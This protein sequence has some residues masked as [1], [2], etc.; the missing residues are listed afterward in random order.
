MSGTSDPRP[1]DLPFLIAD[2]PR[3]P[4]PLRA[5]LIA[6][7]LR[8]EQWDLACPLL[9]QAVAEAPTPAWRLRLCR[10]LLALGEME[11]ARELAL[12]LFHEASDIKAPRSA[13]DAGLYAMG[14]LLAAEGKIEEAETLYRRIRRDGAPARGAALRL[15]GLR[16]R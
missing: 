4:P 10:A 13:S 5:R 15:A 6:V 3:L 11:V 1:P 12:A 16:L 9:E 8:W 14:D 2:A 7:L